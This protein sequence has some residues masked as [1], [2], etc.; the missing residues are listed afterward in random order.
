[1]GRQDA[2]LLWRQQEAQDH[3]EGGR[4]QAPAS[5][6]QLVVMLF[7]GCL[8]FLRR[9]E[10]AAKALANSKIKFDGTKVTGK[11]DGGAKIEGP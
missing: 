6:G 7:D 1:M 4:G 9:A 11:K 2:L 10:A 8:R 3:G 5:P